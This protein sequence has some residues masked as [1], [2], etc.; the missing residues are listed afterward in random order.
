MTKF[1]LSV[2]QING[3]IIDIP[4]HFILKVSIDKAIGRVEYVIGVPEGSVHVIR[5]EQL[6]T[7]LGFFL[8][9]PVV[10]EIKARNLYL[11]ICIRLYSTKILTM[12]RWSLVVA[13]ILLAYGGQRV[14]VRCSLVV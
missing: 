4:S 10:W 8:H 5:T 2:R 11:F 1:C 7:D 13:C 3:I 6:W 9:S 12:R 14:S